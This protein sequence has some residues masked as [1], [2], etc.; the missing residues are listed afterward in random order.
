MAN[1]CVICIDLLKNKN[2]KW[3]PKYTKH[4]LCKYNSFAKCLD[5]FRSYNFDKFHINPIIN[6]LENLFDLS[7]DQIEILHHL[8]TGWWINMF[9]LCKE[10]HLFHQWCEH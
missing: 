4:P 8:S 10:I 2:L 7:I 5:L 3:A 9:E 6:T 1:K